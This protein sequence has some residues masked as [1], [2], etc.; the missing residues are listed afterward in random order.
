MFGLYGP[1]NMKAYTENRTYTDMLEPCQE[2]CSDCVRLQKFK[3]FHNGNFI[4]PSK[5]KAN[6]LDCLNDFDLNDHG[7]CIV[8]VTNEE[9]NGGIGNQAEFIGKDMKKGIR[10]SPIGQEENDNGGTR[11]ILDIGTELSSEI[12]MKNKMWSAINEHLGKCSKNICS[13]L[14]T[15]YD[16]SYTEKGRSLLR[17]K[18]RVGNQRLHLDGKPDCE[19]KS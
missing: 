16:I 4:P 7:F 19:C 10:F 12:L 6:V 17:S 15:K 14:R 18:G 13:F 11:D 5:E 2:N 9:R 3:S 1:E 8:K